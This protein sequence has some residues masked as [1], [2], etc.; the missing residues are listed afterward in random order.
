MRILSA[1]DVAA[2]LPMEA[3][4]A[5]MKRAFAALASGGVEAPVPSFLAVPGGRGEASAA[6]ARV[7]TAE[8]EAF[9]VR[10]TTRY[11]ANA[12]QGR[13]VG[14]A[15]VL[16]LDPATGRPEALLEGGALAAIET[17]ATSAVATDLLARRSS[18][19]LAVLGTGVQARTQV[20]AVCHVRAIET[21]QVYGRDHSSARRFAAEIAGRGPVP[22]EVVIQ[23]TPAAAIGSADVVCTA[24][25]SSTPVFADRE[26]IPGV[27]INGVGSVT[28]A[29][30][31]IPHRTIARALLVVDSRM[32]ALA[33][34]GDVIQA[35]AQGA[36]TPEH[37]HAELGE[38]VLGRVEGRTSSE[39]VTV[40][41]S[42][43]LPVQ[44]TVAAAIALKRA[45]E[46][47]IGRE[48]RWT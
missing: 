32:A 40:F 47:E 26:L 2:A 23:R 27:H 11:P 17:G 42:V 46:Q 28:P 48:V 33:D 38:L 19:T 25:S 4:I 7:R 37:I 10:V 29:A 21:V 13:P 44:D 15:A 9:G 1:D 18:R 3:A 45:R 14:Q 22:Q 24:T 30:A 35:I 8:G 41:K 31:E 6:P 5:G 16:L 12:E 43:G 39:Q 34:A 36:I 20:E